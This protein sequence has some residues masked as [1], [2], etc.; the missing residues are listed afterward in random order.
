[1]TA[2]TTRSRENTRARLLDA[3][4]QVFAEVGLEGASVENI[5]ERAGFT[6]GAFYSNFES[7]D[8]LFLELTSVVAAARLETIRARIDAFVARGMLGSD[9]DALEL[10]H[11]IM[12]TGMDDR[13]DVMLMSEI[14]N[15]ALRSPLFAEAYLV[16]EQKMTAS[17]EGII[18]G[19]VDSGAFSLRVDVSTAAHLLTSIWEGTMVRCA[20]SGFD[21]EKLHRAGGAALADMVELLLA[22]GHSA[23]ASSAS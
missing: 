4:A 20:I 8:A 15:H 18:R 19:I 2:P 10:V 13:L 7:K 17:I 23:G 9:L 11:Q 22:P 3:A 14:R 21:G 12:E 1:M 16:Q 6:R 5:C